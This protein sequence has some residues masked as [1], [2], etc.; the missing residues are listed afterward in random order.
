MFALLTIAFASFIMFTVLLATFFYVPKGMLEV[1]TVKWAAR[2]TNFHKVAYWGL[3]LFLIIFANLFAGLLLLVA[4]I[5]GLTFK[6]RYSAAL[7]SKMTESTPP[8]IPV[9]A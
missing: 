5:V 3:P 1:R 4:A 8:P 6:K 9:A 7:L 2:Y